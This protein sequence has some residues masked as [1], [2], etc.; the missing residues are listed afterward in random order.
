MEAKPNLWLEPNSTDD[1]SRAVKT[2][3]QNLLQIQIWI[4]NKNASTNSQKIKYT[5]LPDVDEFSNCS[6]WNMEQIGPKVYV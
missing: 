1:D 4:Q 2:C 5:V 3:G 6:L